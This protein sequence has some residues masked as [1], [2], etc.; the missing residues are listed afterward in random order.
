MTAKPLVLFF[1][2]ID[3][4]DLP[5]VG[6]KGANLG[7]MTQAGFPVPNGFAVTV[8]SYMQFL[9]ENDL[10]QKLEDIVKAVDVDKQ[11]ELDKAS[12]DIE[13]LILAGYVPTEVERDVHKAY[14]KLSGIFK[15][16]QVAVRSSATAED[17]PDASFAGQ[18]ATY[19][20]IKGFDNLMKAVMDCWAS[21]FTPR[22]IFYRKQNKIKHDQVK[23]SVIVQKMVQSEVSGVMFTINPVTNEKDRIIIESVWGLGEMIVQGSVTPDHYVVQKETFDILS[24][25]ISKQEIQL[26][27][28]GEKTIETDVP[29]KIQEEQKLPDDMIIKMAK[30]GNK[31]QEHYY[32]PQDVEW[33]K[34]G[35]ELYIVQT[36]PITT[37]ESIDKR[38][39]EVE[40]DVKIIDAPILKGAGASPGLGAGHVKVLKNASEI[41]KV[42]SG[43]VLVAPMTS[44]D[45][46]PAMKKAAA[47][48]TN[49]GGQT[50]HAAIVSRELGIP[51]VVGTGEATQKLKDD[52]VVTVDGAKGLVYMGSKIKKLKDAAPKKE[53][54]EDFKG[55]TATKV[56]VNLAEVDLARRV[57]KENVDGVGLLRAEFMIADIGM[58]PKEAIL[59]KKQGV[60]VSKL[61][62]DLSVFCEAFGDRPV[63]YR[64]TD[65]K[66]NEY[67][68]LPGGEKWEPVEPNP[69]LGYRGAFRYINDPEVFTLEL[70]AIKQVREKHKN[71]WLEIPFV[72]SPEELEKVKR[73]VKA[74]GFFED[75]TF[76]FWLMV[77][78]PINVIL[79]ED[80]IKVGID[81]I[82]FGSNDLTMLITGTDRDNSEVAEAFNERSPAVSWA[83][84]RVIK[85]CNKAGVTS[86][87]CGQ[88]PSTYDDL[89]EELV[90]YG[91]TS[92]SI[93]P[94]AIN[95]VRKVIYEAE[96]KIAN[97]R[98]H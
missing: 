18:Q 38:N 11:E 80:Y 76:K 79:I 44:P 98:S 81:G 4:H 53:K 22:A 89:V 88:A 24:K 73:I 45:F 59:N 35:N 49:E 52:D 70:R 64:A 31:L 14:K 72:R 20:N 71:L 12:K 19:L 56:Y 37:I 3:K 5:S 55:K 75:P 57:A 91:I 36:R 47:I 7:E 2:E 6:G 33:A 87:I 66:T 85:A 84:E 41:S 67:R 96:K 17:L 27:K 58:H 15:S 60:F 63:V 46:V 62:K 32:F 1:K 65:F 78:I 77:E 39:L 30:I 23:I 25:E 61:H 94:D 54:E 34:E 86:S 16:A 9:E 50:S 42:H 95:R 74:E 10:G 51:C 48:I 83:F 97:R 92:M 68:S 90:S 29:T 93:N 8:A 26:T 43:D 21:L 13:K 28:K 40:G 69:M 82:S